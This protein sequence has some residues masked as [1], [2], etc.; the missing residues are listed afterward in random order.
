MFTAIADVNL[1]DAT[2]AIPCYLTVI[3]MP[4]TYSIAEGI[5]FGTISY[6]VLNLLAGRGKKLNL[7]L[8]V[9]AV[10]FLCKYVLL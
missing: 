2:E 9:L 8:Y 4:F 7:L 3:A 1:Y 5:A 6:V 10:I